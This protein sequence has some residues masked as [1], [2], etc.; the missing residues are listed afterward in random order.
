MESEVD[1]VAG[2]RHR[3]AEP[4][5]A[6]RGCTQGVAE[7]EDSR[8]ETR[9]NGAVFK[10]VRTAPREEDEEQ[11]TEEEEVGSILPKIEMEIEKVVHWA[12]S[13]IAFEKLPHWLRDNKFLQH[14]HRPPMNSFRGCFKSIFRLHTET[15]NIWT[16]LLGFVFFVMLSLGVYVFGDYI[17]WLFEDIQIHKL[18]W[19]EQ[20]MLF[21]FYLG[22]MACLCCSFLFHMFSSHSQRIFVMF[23]RLD[24]SG[25][26]FLIT[27]SSLPAYYY[28]F[29]CMTVE[30]YLHMTILVVLCTLSITISLWSKFSTPQY[31]PLRA[32]VFLLFG[33]YGFIPSFH[34]LQ[35]VGL[36]KATTAFAGWELLLMGCL[37]ICGTCFYV[38]RI[39][40]RF[41]PG[42]FDIWV[43]S[44]QVFHV[45]V[46]LAALVHYD[47]LLSM[48]K[49]RQSAGSCIDELTVV[50][51]Q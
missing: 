43:S 42:K 41:F 8:E 19:D 17:T 1:V 4:S 33:L 10:V 30:K 44:H 18:P 14:N 29:Y 25:I 40:E 34:I 24:Y 45:F 12:W 47:T 21:F 22:A 49:Y 36:A 27:G 20:I 15:W 35:K 16:H 32:T 39:P 23:S 13:A 7:K 2:L 28:G 26:S 50:T 9:E 5:Q 48:V 11:E 38:T 6:S 37:Y 46:I 31:R 51:V 3:K